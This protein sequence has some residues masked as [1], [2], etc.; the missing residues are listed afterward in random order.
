MKNKLSDV[1]D[2]LF[3]QLERLNDDET[4][5]EAN[6]FEK[7]IK[8]ARAITGVTSQI[9]QNAKVALDAKKYLDEAGSESL[10]NMFL[11]DNKD[12]TK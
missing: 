8:R 9:V 4:L 3:E 11:L 6:N 2:Y 5:D 7:E 1:N 12:N 10:P